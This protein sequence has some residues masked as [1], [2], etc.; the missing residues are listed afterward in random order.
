VGAL[1]VIVAS[2]MPTRDDATTQIPSVAAQAFVAP[3]AAPAVATPVY[4]YE[5]AEPVSTAH[6][7]EAPRK[8]PAIVRAG[9]SRIAPSAKSIAPIASGPIAPSAKVAPARHDD[10]VNTVAARKEN[11]V[12]GP[13]GPPPVTITGCLEISTAGDEFRLT[14]T[15]GIDAPTSRTWRS[16]FLKKRSAPVAL[17]ALSDPRGLE[18]QVGK[19][20]AATGLLA[21]SELKVRSLNVVGPSCE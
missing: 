10:A 20:V 17:V 11:T 2:Q 8:K 16:G 15:E 19:R 9:K 13:A 14:D 18:R 12:V 5:P 21:N 3:V 6:A 7:V 1:V 4:E